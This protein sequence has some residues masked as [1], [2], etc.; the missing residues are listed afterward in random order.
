[1]KNFLIA[2]VL[3]CLV[4]GILGQSSDS[5]A[6]A[7]GA[8]DGGMTDGGDGMTDSPGSDVTIPDNGSAF[9]SV[10]AV[11]MLLPVVVALFRN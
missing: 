7:T 5:P 8:T 1:M 6:D 10:T 2:I 3:F 9:L 11:S 4:L